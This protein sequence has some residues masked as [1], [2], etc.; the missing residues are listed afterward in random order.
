[1]NLKVKRLTKTAI[2]PYKAYATD[3]GFDVFADEAVTIHNGETVAVS[4]GIALE[5]PDGYYGRLKARSVLTLNSALRVQEGTID[6]SYR[7]E[8]KIIAEIKDYERWFNRFNIV[9]SSK[10]DEFDIEK[11]MKL[12]QLIIQPVPQFEIVEADEL[13]E[14]DRGENGFGSTGV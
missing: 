8:V 10:T 9:T 13:S 7:G 5:I 1:M 3:G 4:T 2:L 12:A 14:S 11:G 6:S